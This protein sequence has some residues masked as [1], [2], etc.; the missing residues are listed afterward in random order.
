MSSTYLDS[1][2]AHVQPDQ[3]TAIP[4]SGHA[5]VLHLQEVTHQ[6]CD[7]G[8]PVAAQHE[9]SWRAGIG[10]LRHKVRQDAQR[11]LLVLQP[12]GAPPPLLIILFLAVPHRSVEQMSSGEGRCSQSIAVG[13]MDINVS[14]LPCFQ[15]V[16][17][18]TGLKRKPD[19]QI[20]HLF[21]IIL[22]D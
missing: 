19:C 21:Y 5:R 22:S 13:N 17:K 8:L 1:G 2:H 3:H 14:N 10:R 9:G 20:L 7:V 15:R 16:E 6:F 11:R 12:A 18:F 4:E